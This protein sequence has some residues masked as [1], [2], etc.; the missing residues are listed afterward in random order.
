MDVS[1][2]RILFEE[3]EIQRRVKV[4]GQRL[5]RDL[6]LED[7]LFVSIV[8]GS[9]LFLADLIRTMTEPVRYEFV[10]MHF[11]AGS[12]GDD[13][14]LDVHYPISMPVKDQEIL[15]IKDVVSSGVIETYLRTQFHQLGAS[16][17]LFA[18]LIDV[19]T[20]RKTDFVPDYRLFEAE[21][22]G[23][24]VG[25]GLKYQG[26]YGNLSYIGEIVED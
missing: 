11:S 21:R 23:V 9:V 15:V 5:R 17:T 24:F 13:E 22:H 10:Q 25:Y 16:K 6:A 2:I 7:P 19:P 26:R 18:A 20:G 8:G 3:S 1:P 4:L 12:G 14:I